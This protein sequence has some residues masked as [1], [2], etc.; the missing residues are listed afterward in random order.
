MSG[1]AAV[2]LRAGESRD[3]AALVVLAARDDARPLT[4]PVLVADLDGRL[5][6]A[7]SLVDCAVIADP[8]EPTAALVELLR[9]R[10]RQLGAG[11]A[12]SRRR[13][14]LGWIGRRAPALG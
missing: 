6:A 9:A 1:A 5:L 12:R 7:V 10:V 2:T 13:G 4:W 14:V 11:C 8:Y 3:I